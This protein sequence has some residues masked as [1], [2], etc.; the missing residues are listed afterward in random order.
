LEAATQWAKN[1]GASNVLTAVLINKKI[2]NSGRRIKP[3][4]CCFE[5]QDE[6]V[7]GFGM[8]IDGYW[9]NLDSIYAI[10]NPTKFLP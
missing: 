10:T 2:N 4:F 3:D 6:F 9:R 8:D 5:I 1:N 7:F